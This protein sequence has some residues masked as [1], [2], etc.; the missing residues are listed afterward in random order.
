MN[1]HD[2]QLL[3]LG[4]QYA[5]YAWP[6]K[7][8]NETNIH[9]FKKHFGVHPLTAEKLWSDLKSTPNEDA[10]VPDDTKPIFILIGLRH[11]WRYE[12]LEILGCFFNMSERSIRK[13]YHKSVLA[14]SLLFQE[15]VP[16]IESI[17]DDAI[18]IL[19]IDG[20]HCPIE[21]P[22][23][24]DSKWSSHKLGDSGGLAYEVGLRIHTNDLA[25][26]HGPFPPGDFPDLKIFRDSLKGKLESLNSNLTVKKRVSSGRL[27]HHS[28]A[29]YILY[30][31]FF[32][33]RLRL[34]RTMGTQVNLH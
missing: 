12:S 31:P 33:F 25:W 1:V 4:L 20:T 23:P 7:C 34:L 29:L 10:R 26:V 15:V 14:L 9:R 22:K 6:N 28:Q 13:I 17:N 24:W 3:K 16:P 30:L 8:K 5:G 18:F 27:S 11:L 19:S 32:A 2:S 21:E